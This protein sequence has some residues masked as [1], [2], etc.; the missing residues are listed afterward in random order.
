[1]I[2]MYFSR[3][4]TSRLSVFFASV[5]FSLF[6]SASPIVYPTYVGQTESQQTDQTL[7]AMS[8]LS[9]L[10]SGQ[11]NGVVSPVAPIV[12]GAIGT[13]S[14]SSRQGLLLPGESSIHQL[15]PVVDIE[16]A[17]PYGANIFAGGYET[18][19]VDGLNDDYQVAAGDKL[20]IWLWGAVNYANLAT[21]DNQGNIFIPEVGPI[22]VGGISASRVNEFVTAKVKNVYRKN[23]NVYINL[24]TA[25]PISVYVTGPVIR[26][27]QYA[28]MASDSLLYF[29]KRAGGI[30]SDR[31]SYRNIKVIRD[32]QEI[33]RVD[34]YEFIRQGQLPKSSFQDGDVILVGQQGATVNVSG[35]ARNAFRFEF[36]SSSAKGSE[37]ATY[38]RPLARIS[39][40]GIVG[41]R[42]D[43]PFS[44]YLPYKD[45]L[46]YSLSDGDKVVYN[47]DLHAQV[48]DV[49]VSGSYLG[50]SYYAIDKKTRLYDLLNHI[51]IEEELA[52]FKSIYILR[53]SVAQKQKEMIERS[54]QRLER[55]VFTAPVSSDSE[56]TIRAAEAEMVMQFA[57]K[58]RQVD[59]L[60]KVIVSEDGNIANIQLEQG[61]QVVIP[62]KTDLVQVGGEVLM[63][64]AVVFNKKAVLEDYVAWAGGFTDRADD[65]RIA[66]V[67]AN[68][69]IDF[70]GDAVVQPGDQILVLP[71]VDV[72]AM[73]TVKDITQIVYQIA[74]AAN[75]ILD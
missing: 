10:E 52:D 36:S 28:G 67:H 11:V 26:P 37:L 24:M 44:M 60:G 75:V 46:N 21:V 39:H 42:D 68:G 1:V 4:K 63:P 47:D 48:Y 58:A 74:I 20:Q 32:R 34:L 8:G 73:Q 16:A 72:K 7:S 31:G 66:V 70:S 3:V 40:V 6:S 64:Q 9:S 27:G 33:L 14:S 54:L 17:P 65:T 5:C 41:D 45:Y 15:L 38:A 51:E 12:P 25:T 22:S 29:L 59:P 56:A 19:R 23:V 57:E 2:I 62:A 30:D 50:P 53:Q 55:S 18:E 49:Q 69:M 61:D 13:Y 71:K 35:G 43:G